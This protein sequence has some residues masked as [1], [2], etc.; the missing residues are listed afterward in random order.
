MSIANIWLNAVTGTGKTT[1]NLAIE[2]VAI[3]VYLLYTWYFMNIN[4]ISL[5]MAWSNEFVY[6]SVIFILSFIYLKSGRW[7]TGTVDRG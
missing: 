4:Y 5:A 3:M 1:V 2:I 6:W 7:K